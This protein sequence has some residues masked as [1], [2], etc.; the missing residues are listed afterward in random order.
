MRLDKLASFIQPFRRAFHSLRQRSGA[1]S[2]QVAAS[3]RAYYYLALVPICCWLGW[4]A[5][6]QLGR[7]HLSEDALY[8]ALDISLYLSVFAGILLVAI[9]FRFRKSVNWVKLVMVLLFCGLLLAWI[10]FV[11]YMRVGFGCC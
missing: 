11:G 7:K 4:A 3:H 2:H 1:P 10:T 9:A 5:L 6:Y 8:Q